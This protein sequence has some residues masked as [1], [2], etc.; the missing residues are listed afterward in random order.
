MI[1][2]RLSAL[3]EELAKKWGED[4]AQHAMQRIVE[5]GWHLD[6]GENKVEHFARVVAS[7]YALDRKMEKARR[8]LFDTPVTDELLNLPSLGQAPEQERRVEARQCLDRLGPE[9]LA[10]GV[11]GNYEEA[12]EALGIPSGTVKSRLH[13][14]KRRLVG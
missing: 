14:A 4:A 10:L 2:A 13:R 1:D 12:G 8:H 7:H 3:W 5:K 9:A 11:M 6:P